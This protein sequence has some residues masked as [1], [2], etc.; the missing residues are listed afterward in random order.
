MSPEALG[1]EI[2]GEGEN[3]LMRVLTG[4]LE[5]SVQTLQRIEKAVNESTRI[6]N[7]MLSKI[8][9]IDR[10]IESGFLAVVKKALPGLE[11]KFLEKLDKIGN[12]DEVSTL[13][14]DIISKLQQAM[15][16]LSIQNLIT[17]LEKVSITKKK[18]GMKEAPEKGGKEAEE[19]KKPEFEV[20]IPSMSTK[21]P[22]PSQKQEPKEKAEEKKDDHLVRPSSFFGS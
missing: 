22:P 16:I 1:P 4:I 8:D 13:L 17:E 3:T 10:K 5:D 19:K 12:F 18:E 21:E 11:A 2:G 20:P 9:L 14:P 7:E 15:Q 6:A